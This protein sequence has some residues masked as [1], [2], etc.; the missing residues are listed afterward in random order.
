MIAALILAADLAAGA[1]PVPVVGG[2]PAPPCAWPTAVRAGTCSGVLIHPEI[3]LL[4][5]H[6][7]APDEIE[8]ELAAAAAR[9]VPTIACERTEQ[10]LP[11][12]GND[13]QWCRLA[14]AQDDIPIVPPLVGCEA[15]A[16]AVGDPVAL[17]GFGLDDEGQWGVKHVAHTEL[18]GFV[19]PEAAIG[20]DGVDTCLGDSGGPAYVEL[21]DGGGWRVLG[22]TSHGAYPCGK[23]GFYALLWRG[24]PWLEEST[25]LDLTPCHDADGTWNPDDRCRDIPLDPGNSHAVGGECVWGPATG[26]VRTCGP[27]VAS[28][29]AEPAQA[30]EHHVGCR[31]LGSGVP[32]RNASFFAVVLILIFA[33]RSLA[34]AHQ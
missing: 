12:D 11:G 14:N 3:V 23:G 5:A 18:N 20:G 21:A 17:V 2:E 22:L 16:L 25:T 26:R 32:S 9:R 8:F 6:C 30:S 33:R 34:G 24:M 7:G 13:F 10:H 31:T 28:D 4:A 1:Y 27:A 29:P 15:E 19:G